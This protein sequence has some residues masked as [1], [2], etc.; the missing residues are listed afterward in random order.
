MFTRG[1][2][3]LKEWRNSLRRTRVFGLFALDDIKPFF[4]S[5]HYGLSIVKLPKFLIKQLLKIK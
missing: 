4:H 3:S 1:E 5:I 2:L